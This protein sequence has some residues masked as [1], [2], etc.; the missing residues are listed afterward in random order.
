MMLAAALA[1]PELERRCYTMFELPLTALSGAAS[2]A[3][4]RQRWV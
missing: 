2:P 4:W 3:I 1:I